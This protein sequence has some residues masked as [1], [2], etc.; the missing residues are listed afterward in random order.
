MKTSSVS[1]SS[2]ILLSTLALSFVHAGPGGRPHTVEHNVDF[3]LTNPELYHPEPIIDLPHIGGGPAIHPPIYTE[4]PVYVHPPVYVKPGCDKRPIVGGHQNRLPH[5]Y[6]IGKDGRPCPGV[7]HVK[8]YVDN[9]LPSN[10]VIGKNGMPCPSK[11][12]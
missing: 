1:F 10:Y 2:L 12:Y 6:V 9:R 7:V 8:P 4:P 3:S 11:G 5:G